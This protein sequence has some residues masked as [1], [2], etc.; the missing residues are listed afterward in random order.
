MLCA[1]CYVLYAVRKSFLGFLKEEIACWDFL[2]N[3]FYLTQ[4]HLFIKGVGERLGSR[5]G[6]QEAL[7]QLSQDQQEIAFWDFLN[8]LFSV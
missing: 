5:A 8:N 1:V 2:T 3:P 6:Q 7:S 4:L